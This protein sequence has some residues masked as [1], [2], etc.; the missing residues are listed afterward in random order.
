MLPGPF[1]PTRKTIQFQKVGNIGYCLGGQKFRAQL[2][3]HP[4]AVLTDH[5]ACLSQL[6]TPRPSAKLAR[7]AMVTQEFNLEIKHRSGRS[8]ASADALSRHPIDD[9]IVC[10]VTGEPGDLIEQSVNT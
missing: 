4:C 8:N 10:S 1:N 7:W 9:A 5:A 3:G 2:L 6:N